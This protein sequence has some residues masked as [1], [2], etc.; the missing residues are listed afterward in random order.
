LNSEQT[1]L[2]NSFDFAGNITFEDVAPLSAK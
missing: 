2:V 1:L